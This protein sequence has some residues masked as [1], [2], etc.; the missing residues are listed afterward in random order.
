[1]KKT[2]HACF[3][4]RLTLKWEVEIENEEDKSSFDFGKSLKDYAEMEW[5]GGD[6]THIHLE[7]NK[8]GWICADK[9][10]DVFPYMDE[11]SSEGSLD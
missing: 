5:T 10:W 11:L 6:L 3:E 2:Y 1:M 7:Q 9:E 8:Y 4:Q